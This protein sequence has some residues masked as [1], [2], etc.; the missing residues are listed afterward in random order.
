MEKPA[1]DLS[2]V[3]L[4]CCQKKLT[5]IK[6]SFLESEA[7]R[8]NQIIRNFYTIFLLRF[9]Y[10]FIMMRNVIIAQPEDMDSPKT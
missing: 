4:L 6:T 10:A 7:K 9:L 1:R 5:A 2:H 8:K 3:C